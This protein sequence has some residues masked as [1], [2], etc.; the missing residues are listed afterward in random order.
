MARVDST[1]GALSGVLGDMVLVRIGD[2][3]YARKK[4]RKMTKAEKKRVS[5]P[6]K[7]TYNRMGQSQRFL[8]ILTKPIAFGFQEHIDGAR[9]PF[10]VCLSHTQKNVFR[11]DGKKYVLD[12]CLFKISLGSLL[13]PQG[14]HVERTPEGLQLQWEDNSWVGSAR[15]TDEAFL[16]LYNPEEQR[17]KWET[18][19]G[20]RAA[21]GYHWKLSADQHAW[22]GH[23]YL[24]FSQV[25][26]WDRKSTVLS[27][28]VYLGWV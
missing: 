1:T 8:K 7:S 2:K 10:H 6:K 25:S 16:V 24:A 15:S 28:S 23:L 26:L 22:K 13:P 27:D 19:G 5:E 18:A 4:R 12:P 3:I 21:G 11:H 17:V 20:Q 9:R 14:V